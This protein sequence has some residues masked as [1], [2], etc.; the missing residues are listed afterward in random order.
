MVESVFSNTFCILITVSFFLFSF[1]FLLYLAAR[2]TTRERRL[3]YYIFV[4]A[5]C[6]SYRK[7]MLTLTKCD[8]FFVRGSLTVVHLSNA[9]KSQTTEL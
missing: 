9:I 5:Y 4:K 6:S 3:V 8:L 7:F 2:T 1:Y